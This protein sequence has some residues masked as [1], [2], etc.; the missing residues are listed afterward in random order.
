MNRLSLSKP[1]LEY[2]ILSL[3]TYFILWKVLLFA[4]ALTS[5]GPGYDTSTLLLK[6]DDGNIVPDAGGLNAIS[7]LLSSYVRWDALYFTQIARR[8]FIFEQEWAFGWG[9][10][11]LLA[12]VAGSRILPEQALYSHANHKAFKHVVQLGPLDA[13]PLAGVLLSHLSHLLSCFALYHLSR[14]V[15]HA[16]PESDRSGFAFVAACLHIIS[17]AG[18]FLSAPYAESSFSFCNLTGFYF[19]SKSFI[20]QS[21]SE[22]GRRDRLLLA[23]GLAFGFATTLRSNGLISG[24]IFC[25]EALRELLRIRD[26]SNVGAKLRYLSVIV[27]SGGL[28]AFCALLPQFIAYWDFCIRVHNDQVRRPWCLHRIPS[29]YAWVQTYY[30]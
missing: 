7:S 18:I 20:A 28:L 15:C 8:G 2:P 17:P 24:S 27:S 4:I 16:M 19:Y 3:T 14:V 10:T 21:Q 29:V 25:F 22:S 11:K 30:W 1:H 9:F 13:E 26:I 12:L 6:T 5:P 23:S